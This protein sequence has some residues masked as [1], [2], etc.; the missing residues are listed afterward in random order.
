MNA[1]HACLVKTVQPFRR[2]AATGF[3]AAV[4]APAIIAAACG[5]SSQP[6]SATSPTA[7]SP[8]AAATPSPTA[9]YTASLTL[10]G[11]ISATVDKASAPSNASN[12]CGGGSVDV[13]IAINGQVWTLDAMAKTYS[14]PAQ[15][16]AG[17]E[18]T[19]MLNAP[20]YDIWMSTAG[21][22]TYKD[23]KSLSMDVT[24]TNLMVPEGPGTSAHLLG[25]VSC[26]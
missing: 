2:V 24:L 21:T 26:G 14:G 18:F 13:E 23:D 7:T 15:Y 1:G 17:S 12:A 10:T 16:K 6:A 19:V 5:G 9:S 8:A 22:A 4:V 20:D 25:S 3:I 11:G